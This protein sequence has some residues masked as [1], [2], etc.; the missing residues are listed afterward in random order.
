MFVNPMKWSL[1][2]LVGNLLVCSNSEI[3]I[4][5]KQFSLNVLKRSR[6]IEHPKNEINSTVVKL[7]KNFEIVAVISVSN[8]KLLKMSKSL[9]F[10]RVSG[11]CLYKCCTLKI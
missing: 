7:I 11:S 6:N 9:V 2:S 1:G 3:L 4:K 10:K 8:G 5:G